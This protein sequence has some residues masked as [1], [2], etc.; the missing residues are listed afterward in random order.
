MGVS[1]IQLRNGMTFL[2]I[3]ED[4]VTADKM[5][6]GTTAHNAKGESITGTMKK[7]PW[8]FTLEDGSIIEKEVVVS[9]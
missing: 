2:D 5:V 7:E 8:V 4:N 9:S 1:K 6:E 3:S